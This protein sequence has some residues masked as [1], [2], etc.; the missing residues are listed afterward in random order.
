MNNITITKKLDLCGEVCPMNL[1]KT[2]IA[3]KELEIGE[4]LVVK[5]DGGEPI[6][7]V[8]RGV[9]EDGHKIIKLEQNEDHFIVWIKKM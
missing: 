1:F 9:K 4:V 5:L 3:L 7:S 6:R 2:K 8:S